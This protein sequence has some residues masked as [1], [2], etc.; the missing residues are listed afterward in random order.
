VRRWIEAQG[1]ALADT[2]HAMLV[3]ITIRLPV[4]AVD[5]ARR[6][7]VDMTQGKAGFF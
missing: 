4:N 5:D 3:K 2:A 7:L 1:Y 6:T